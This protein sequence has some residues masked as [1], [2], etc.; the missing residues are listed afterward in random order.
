VYRLKLHAVP[1][2][3]DDFTAVDRFA[4]HSPYMRLEGPLRG[5]T[6]GDHLNCRCDYCQ[7]PASEKRYLLLSDD[8]PAFIRIC[9]V[10]N[11][12]DPDPTFSIVNAP[13]NG[14]FTY[15]RLV[16][17]AHPIAGLDQ[18]SRLDNLGLCRTNAFP[19]PQRRR[20]S[21]RGDHCAEPP[22]TRCRIQR[23]CDAQG[24]LG[25]CNRLGSRRGRS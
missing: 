12:T 20:R 24:C 9:Q 25:L 4:Q 21:L 7:A 22:V 5:S 11:Y 3:S 23:G 17:E 15:R 16:Q 18:V 14:E 13:R 10:L 8:L 6:G 1:V 2:V 19:V